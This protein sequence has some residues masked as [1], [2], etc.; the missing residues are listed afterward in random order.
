MTRAMLK[1]K[2]KGNSWWYILVSLILYD[3]VLDEGGK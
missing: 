2:R 1:K 3:I